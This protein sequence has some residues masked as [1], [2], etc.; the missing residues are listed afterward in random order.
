MADSISGIMV[1][2]PGAFPLVISRAVSAPSTWLMTLGSSALGM[3]TPT[4]GEPPAATMS[5]QSRPVSTALVR[6]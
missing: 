6:T 4:A 5:S 3:I 2:E 1:I